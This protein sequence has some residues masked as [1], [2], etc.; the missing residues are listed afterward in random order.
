MVGQAAP[1]PVWTHG[2][3]RGDLIYTKPMLLAIGF[4]YR[5]EG[6]PLLSPGMST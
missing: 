4:L 2:E 6:A 3:R 5:P 1:A